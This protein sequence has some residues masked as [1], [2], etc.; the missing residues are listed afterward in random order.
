MQ[1]AFFGLDASAEAPGAPAFGGHGGEGEEGGVDAVVDDGGFFEAGEGVRGFAHDVVAYEGGAFD[2]GEVGGVGAVAGV[3]FSD[4]GGTEHDR[5]G[6]GEAVGLRGLPE[7]VAIGVF[8]GPMVGYV[9]DGVACG[10]H[11]REPLQRGQATGI[12]EEGDVG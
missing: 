2:A 4:A 12:E 10:G 5:G 3:V 6:I 11:C 9:G 1:D 7:F 8:G